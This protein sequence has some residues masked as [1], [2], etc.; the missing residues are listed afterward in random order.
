[1]LHLLKCVL[2]VCIHD[3]YPASYMRMTLECRLYFTNQGYG[4][5]LPICGDNSAT[6]SVVHT[7]VDRSH[8]TYITPCSSAIS[9]F[10]LIREHL[11]R[12]DAYS[13]T[14]LVR[15]FR[16]ILQCCLIIC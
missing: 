13:L 1:M 16:L 12:Y 11:A 3:S 5:M 8:T 4:A 2:D 7:I 9:R 6:A 10:S 15:A 14:M